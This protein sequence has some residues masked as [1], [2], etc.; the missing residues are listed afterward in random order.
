MQPT[1]FWRARTFTEKSL[2]TYFELLDLEIEAQAAIFNWILRQIEEGSRN[3]GQKVLTLFL[4]AMKAE[5]R[6]RG[7]GHITNKENVF[8][9]FSIYKANTCHLTIYITSSNRA[10]WTTELQG[11]LGIL[12]LWGKGL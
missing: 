9:I 5:W 1:T 12:N 2:P 10:T 8:A 4:V 11:N 7:P 3:G 6:E